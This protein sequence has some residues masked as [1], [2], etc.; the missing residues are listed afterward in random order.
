MHAGLLLA[1]GG[2]TTLWRTVDAPSF[3][4]GRNPECDLSVPDDA[5]APVQC[6]LQRDG[7][8]LVLVNHAEDGTKVGDDRIKVEAR[9]AEGDVLLLGPVSATVRYRGEK[10][11][12]GGTRTLLRDGGAGPKGAVLKFGERTYEITRRGVTIGSDA[13]NDVV[14]TDPYVSSFH[15]RVAMEDGRCMV[16]D[17]GSRNGV[18]IGEQKV[19]AAEVK[20]PAKVKIGRIDVQIAAGESAVEESAP[21]VDYVGV[22]SISNEVRTVAMRMAT[23]D[24]P[25]LVLGETGTGKEVA[26]RLIGTSG[27]RA[28]K[29]FVAINCGALS[30]SLIESE[31]FGHEKGAFTGAEKRKLGAFEQAQGG[32]LFLDEVGELPLD[33]QPQLLRVLETGILRRVGGIED[34]PVRVRVVAAT[35]R[36]LDD[37]VLA[38]RFREDLFHRLHVLSLSLIPLRDHP[39]DI[40]VLV[41][42]FLKQFV[43]DG[44]P[45]TFDDAAMKKLSGHVWPGNIRE[46]RNVVQRA[47]LMRAT[48]KL[49]AK[50]VVF[51]PNTSKNRLEAQNAKKKTLADIERTAIVNA[52][53]ENSGKKGDA[54]DA[55][56]IS[57]STI[58][59]KIEEYR[60]DI[61]AEI[62]AAKNK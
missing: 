48:D 7:Q 46:L 34:V 38:G 28:G 31:L 6:V 33:L 19:H 14:I 57:R 26:A 58:H 45:V 56:G 40:P 36:Q 47:V 32:T 2:R 49:V 30:R 51:P 17:G 8:L 9:L 60:I 43:P 39:E 11:S 29:P 27:P 23:N 55:L 53:V 15:A 21:A 54:A 4:I 12:E 44:S 41:A 1:V 25:V 59:R 18:F 42:H 22:S 20:P 61:D 37:E 5:V 10:A 35:N 62:E 24:A 50:D 13:S 3:T 16:H 52:I